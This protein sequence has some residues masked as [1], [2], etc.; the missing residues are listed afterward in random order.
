MFITITNK[1][2]ILYDYRGYNAQLREI[3]E[4]D[5]KPTEFWN[6]NIRTPNDLSMNFYF[7]GILGYVSYINFTKENINKQ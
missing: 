2:D 7:D 6:M 3:E 1:S 5:F 4:T